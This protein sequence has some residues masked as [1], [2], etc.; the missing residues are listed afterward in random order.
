[1]ERRSGANVIANG[2]NQRVEQEGQATHPFRQQRAVQLQAGA[3]VDLTLA[4]ER[5]K[6]SFSPTFSAGH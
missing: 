3:G 1:M 6:R 2:V 4:M 5:R